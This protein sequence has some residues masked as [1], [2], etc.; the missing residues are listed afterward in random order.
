MKLIATGSDVGPINWAG[1][2]AVVTATT[3]TP[4]SA[5]AASTA[6]I[7]NFNVSN[8]TAFNGATGRTIGGAAFPTQPSAPGDTLGTFSFTAN[9]TG[10]IAFSYNTSSLI[11]NTADFGGVPFTTS[12]GLSLVGTS[13]SVVPEPSSLAF[14]GLIGMSLVGYRRRRLVRDGS[15]AA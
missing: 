14:V 1:F 12:N 8:T 6:P 15:Q 11:N 7:F 13:I 9:A 3:A 4:N 2:N 10:P 5:A